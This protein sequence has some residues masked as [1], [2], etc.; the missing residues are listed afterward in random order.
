LYLLPQALA[1]GVGPRKHL[2]IVPTMLMTISERKQLISRI[3]TPPSDVKADSHAIAD[4]AL[5]SWER[6][7][8]HLMPLIG[9]AGF[10]SL[11]FRAIHLA[12][13]ECP[14]LTLLKQCKSTDELFQKLKED[15]V[16]LDSGLTGHCSNLLLTKFTDLV[17][18]M[19][20]DVLMGQILRSA[21][22]DQ[23]GLGKAQE[24][25]K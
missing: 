9:E 16:A 12:L 19:I 24:I 13:P 18:S 15:L 17:S 2:F 7:A 6:I 25:T 5:W 1:S 11:Y 8:F 22:D 3:L 20:G 4:L 21:W 23:S 14:N 10:Q